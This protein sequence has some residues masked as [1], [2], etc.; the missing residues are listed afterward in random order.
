MPPRYLPLS[1]LVAILLFASA[2]K[3]SPQQIS[4]S[5]HIEGLKDS[6]LFI[7]IPKEDSYHTFDSYETYDFNNDDYKYVPVKNGSFSWTQAYNGP[8]HLVLKISSHTVTL[9]TGK[10]DIEILGR[11]D[12]LAN[13]RISGSVAQQEFEALRSIMM[14]IWKKELYLGGALS[15]VRDTNLL[16]AIEPQYDSVMALKKLKTEQF[17]ASHPGSIVS[18]GIIKELA[19]DGDPA[20]LDS[21]NKLLTP[22][23]VATPAGQRLEEKLAVLRRG[24][25]GQ[26]FRDFEQ[27][28]LK[29]DTVRLADYKGRYL[30]VF[31]WVS[32]TKEEN[33]EVLRLY[34]C[35]RKKGFD[36]LGVFI[37]EDRA[38]WKDMVTWYGLPWKQVS[39]LEW[40]HGRLAR[41]Y[42]IRSM[43]NNFL[44]D[45]KG[46]IIGRDM[47]MKA[48]ETKLC[49]VVH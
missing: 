43:P 41:E 48:L 34:K 5:G 9:F 10:T 16:K 18:V 22:E 12:S 46:V 30:L 35:Y 40:I 17:I 36:V 8:Q 27:I 28:D 3:Q 13:L 37:G 6:I 24:A 19:Y 45:P 42:G 26:V 29:G 7:A 31:Y 32:Y 11:A 21:L 39:D 33:L 2:C 15:K 38:R 14:E 49:E 1:L 44:L 25:V 23:I 4:I 20:Y 47:S